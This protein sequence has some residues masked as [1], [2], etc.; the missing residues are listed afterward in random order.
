MFSCLA[1]VRYI[2]KLSIKCICVGCKSEIRR[3]SCT[4]AGCHSTNS[5]YRLDL[6]AWY[7][8]TT[9]LLY[10]YYWM[11]TAA[12]TD[13]AQWRVVV[14]H[15]RPSYSPCYWFPPPVSYPSFFFPFFSLL[16]LR[17]RSVEPRVFHFLVVSFLSH[18]LLLSFT[19]AP[20][21]LKAVL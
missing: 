8:L 20:Q 18:L 5:G 4:Y 11:S 1:S 2:H 21:P 7:I 17:P 19:L 12:A 6:N 9:K 16:F 14:T 3:S 13:P 10:Y 15:F